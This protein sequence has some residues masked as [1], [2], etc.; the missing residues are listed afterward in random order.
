MNDIY[1][2]KCDPDLA[3]KICRQVTAT[4]PEWFGIPEANERYV[5]GMM[6]RVSFFACVASD[7]IGMIT[8]DKYRHHEMQNLKLNIIEA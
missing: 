3:M 4:L 8:M 1:I 7:Y 2:K 5:Q 6:D